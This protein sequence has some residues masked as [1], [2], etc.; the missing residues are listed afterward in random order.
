MKD[1]KIIEISIGKKYYDDRGEIKTLCF[2]EKNYIVAKRPRCMP[3]IMT[4][5]QFSKTFNFK[6]N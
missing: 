2:V 6:G 5:N 3:F 4:L 1:R